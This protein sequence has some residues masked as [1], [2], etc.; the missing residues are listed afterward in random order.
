MGDI[1]GCLTARE[2]WKKL[3]TIY[4][5]DSEMSLALLFKQWVGYS[6]SSHQSVEEYIRRHD[7][8]YSQLAARGQVY[9]DN[10]RKML[11]LAGLN[12]DFQTEAK[13]FSELERPYAVV[14]GDLRN[15]AIRLHGKSGKPAG[16][17]GR[18]QA[19]AAT[20]KN[21]NGKAAGGKKS[22]SGGERP[23]HCLNCGEEGHFHRKC[24]LGSKKNKDGSWIRLCYN[25]KQPGHVSARCPEKKGS[26]NNAK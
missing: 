18:H 25:C 20:W 14:C 7:Q 11:L 3:Q 21:W 16:G 22:G 10:Y 8:L 26:G 24:P 19:N 12:Q 2:V 17:V 9:S 15:Q 23:T 13:L 6:Q 1:V 5:N 4:E